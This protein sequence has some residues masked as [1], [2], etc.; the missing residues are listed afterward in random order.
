MLIAIMGW[1]ELKYVSFTTKPKPNHGG[2]YLSLGTTSDA[3]NKKMNASIFEGYLRDLQKAI[4]N[5]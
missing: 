5:L 1:K 3:G 2:R 4:A